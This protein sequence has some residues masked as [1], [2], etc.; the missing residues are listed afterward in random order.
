MSIRLA[1]PPSPG[2]TRMAP[3][4]VRAIRLVAAN[5]DHP[6]GLAQGDLHAALRHFARHGLAAARDARE[7]AVA[8]ARTGDRL[9]FEHWLGICR[10]LDRRMAGRVEQSAA[11]SR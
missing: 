6:S 8:A 11:P 9:G 5:D 3:E 7:R 10:A 1:S 2:A 4:L